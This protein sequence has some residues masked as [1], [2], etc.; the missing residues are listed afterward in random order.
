[1]NYQL[2]LC[3]IIC[4]LLALSTNGQDELRSPKDFL[5]YELGE[6]FTYHYQVVDYYNYVAETSNQVK[7]TQYGETNERRPLVA[8]MVSSAENIRNLEAIRNSNLYLAGYL[9]RSAKGNDKPIIWLSYNIHGDEAAG[10][11]AALKTLH[12][13]LTDEKAQ[14]WLKDVIVIIDPCENPDGRDRYVN[15]YNMV[16]NSP[17]NPHLNSIEHHQPWPGGRDRKSV[18]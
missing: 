14:E 11:E 12:F 8:A 5:G 18:V 9:N 15:W 7:I 13:L 17:S 6:Y 1:M 3:K 16:M 2:L 4:L 10:T